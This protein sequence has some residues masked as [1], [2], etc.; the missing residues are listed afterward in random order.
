M[1][2]KLL[3]DI[4]NFLQDLVLKEDLSETSSAECLNFVQRLNDLIKPP[5]LPPRQVLQ[6]ALTANSFETQDEQKESSSP[7][8]KSSEPQLPSTV[9]ASQEFLEQQRELSRKAT[10]WKNKE[11]AAANQD[12]PASLRSQTLPYQ[13]RRKRNTSKSKVIHI[14]YNHLTVFSF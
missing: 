3:P 7:S 1:L 11:Q 9:L 5:S 4:R 13:S 14:T 12:A 8:R 2:N 10:L 6:R